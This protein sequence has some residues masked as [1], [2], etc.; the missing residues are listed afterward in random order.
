MKMH[1]R[2]LTAAVMVLAA[3]SSTSAWAGW[4]C[5]Y[6]SNMGVGRVWAAED[7]EAARDGAMDNCKNAKLTQCRI[8]SCRANVDS[9]ADA[10]KIWPRTPGI[11]YKRN[12]PLCGGPGEPACDTQ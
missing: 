4:G 10:D 2:V 8:I 11:E 7:E 6:H 9:M 3:A 5:G 1:K 12:G